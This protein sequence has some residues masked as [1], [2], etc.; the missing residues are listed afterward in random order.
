MEL[1]CRHQV[2]LRV[3][4][5]LADMCTIRSGFGVRPQNDPLHLS[6]LPLRRAPSGLSSS[7]STRTI[8]RCRSGAYHARREC[9]SRAHEKRVKTSAEQSGAAHGAA[10]NPD[11][12][13]LY[14]PTVSTA[15]ILPLQDQQYAF[16]PGHGMLNSLHSTFIV[17]HCRR[18]HAEARPM[19]VCNADAEKAFDSPQDNVPF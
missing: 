18:S 19:H 10:P 14:P 2:D 15:R 5:A 6:G 16:F 12:A 11:A 1:L 7:S 13:P 8:P 3:Q 17:T 4:G 9:F